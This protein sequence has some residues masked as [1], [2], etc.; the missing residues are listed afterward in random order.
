MV[1]TAIVELSYLDALIG[2]GGMSYHLAAGQRRIVP[3]AIAY[4][5]SL[6]CPF[7]RLATAEAHCVFVLQDC[8]LPGWSRDCKND[9]GCSSGLSRSG[10]SVS[11][12]LALEVANSFVPGLRQNA[13]DRSNLAMQHAGTAAQGPITLRLTVFSGNPSSPSQT[14]LLT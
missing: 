1:Q 7:R 12:M 8:R 4:L 3:N 11:T 2:G 5:V 6:E 10:L 9:H 13:T 14:T